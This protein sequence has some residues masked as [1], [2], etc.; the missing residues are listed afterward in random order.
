MSVLGAKNLPALQSHHFGIETLNQKLLVIMLL[1]PYNR[2]I[3]ELKR[4]NYD[5]NMSIYLTYNRT[6]LELKH[7]DPLHQSGDVVLTI[8]PFWN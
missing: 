8:A 4:A 6:I 1:C 2:T 3:L 7:V 5:P